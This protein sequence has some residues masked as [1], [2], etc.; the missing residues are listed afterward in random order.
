MTDF[1]GDD[2]EYI[3]AKDRITV[4]KGW[5][6]ICEIMY[7]KKFDEILCGNF[8]KDTGYIHIKL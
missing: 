4:L 6:Y 3:Q 5:M 1:R 2:L 7:Q 8:N